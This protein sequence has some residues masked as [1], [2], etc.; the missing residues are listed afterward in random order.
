MGSACVMTTEKRPVIEI[1]CDGACRGNPGPGGWGTLL[2]D[3]ENGNEKELYGFKGRTTNNEMEMTAA[4]EGLN[5]LKKPSL[6]TVTTDSNY[7]V[8]GITG[9]IFGWK[10]NQWKTANKKPVKNKELWL[11][12][13]E[14]VKRHQ[15]KWVWVKGHNGH[16]EN[17]RADALANRG[18]DE[19]R[20]N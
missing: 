1:F 13:D 10:K 3:P 6:V 2:R 12:L 14:A 8:K 16:P 15:V 4:I 9:W 17:E 19:Q 20:G 11:M 7:L 5:A 18:I